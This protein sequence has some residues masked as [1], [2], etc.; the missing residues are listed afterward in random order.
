MIQ[1]SCA[2]LQKLFFFLFFFRIKFSSFLHEKCTL[3]VLK[4]TCTLLE[5]PLR[6]STVASRYLDLVYL[7]NRFSRSE[8]LVPD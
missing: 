1:T 4:H 2:V 8:N 5:L 3:C 7:K 6:H